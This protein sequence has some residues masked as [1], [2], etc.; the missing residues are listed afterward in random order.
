[1]PGGCAV[2]RRAE[3]WTGLF[4]GQL[5]EVPIPILATPVPADGFAIDGHLLISV[6][7]GHSD[8]DDTTVLHAPS[9]GLVAVGDV[10]YS[11]VHQYLA[12]TPG[13]GLEAR[14]RALDVVEALHPAHVVA[15]HKGPSAD[16][17]PADID[18]T[19]RYL[20]VAGAL[21]ATGPTRAQFYS[22]VLERYPQRNNPH[23]VWLSA[24]RLIKDQ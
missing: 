17:S 23:T 1:M 21:L 11:N 19:R 7:A 18:E 15:G 16:D 10:V 5:L 3:L 6:E 2:R 20:D 24:T 4:P 13:S 22:H 12:E 9:I 8:T 14:H